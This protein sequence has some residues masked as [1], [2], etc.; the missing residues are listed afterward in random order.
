MKKLFL[1]LAIIS[2]VSVA[3]AQDYSKKEYRDQVRANRATQVTAEMN[4]A[5]TNRNFTFTAHYMSSN[6][7]PQMPVSTT[8][9]YLSIFPNYMDV[10]LPY[11]VFSPVIPT[12][13]AFDFNTSNYTFASN[14]VNGMWY[15][16]IKVENVMNVQAN[17]NLPEADYNIH[18]S[19][20]STTGVATMTIVP[21]FSPMITY[22]G[23]VRLN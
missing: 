9:N 20:S 13:R 7:G 6:F 14:L 12:P 16:T 2:L 11:L 1:T 5:V 23:I 4:Q 10:N 19:F 8:A 22:Y 15:V 21:D 3:T 18:I 17:P